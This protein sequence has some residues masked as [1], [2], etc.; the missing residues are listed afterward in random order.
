MAS[1]PVINAVKKRIERLTSDALTGFGPNS[2]H[3]SN[4]G[5]RTE[6]DNTLSLNQSILEKELQN[7]PSSLDAIFNSMY[8]SSSTLLSVSG[9]VNKPPKAGAYS[10]LMTAY[11]A[12][13]VTGLVDTDTTPEVTI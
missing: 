11:V 5:V 6:K 7:N 13:A 3:L 9:G 12:G 8:S 4:L 2:V 1:D 10:F